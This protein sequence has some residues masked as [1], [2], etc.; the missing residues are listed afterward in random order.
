MEFSELLQKHRSIRRYKPDS[1]DPELIERV[2][3]DA[4]AGAST[5]GNLNCV[6]MVLTRDP[7]RKRRLYE[8]HFEQPM[9][10]EAPLVMTFCADWFR[11]REWLRLRGARD[12]FNNL[13]GY[14]VAAFDAIILAQNVCLGF[15]ANGL[16]ICYMGT[17][18]SS[19][20]EI[21]R[22]LELPDTCVPVTT[23]VVGYP[24]EEPSQRD[25]LP[26]G[27]FLHDEVY[28]PLTC[29]EIETVYE[30][31][32]VRGWQRY[33]SIPELKALIEERGIQSLAQFYTSEVKY[34]PETFRE[35]SERLRVL[36][37]DKHFLP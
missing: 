13:L 3:A 11:T 2:C 17:T 15:E 4:L 36:L 24:A 21:A 12:N 31:R 9:V 14:H 19:M 32:E 26:V 25:R 8:L 37:E 16:G 23:I 34:D 33:M 27:T 6:T 28:R 30:Q 20:T 10:L 5:S 7:D 1:I 35:D 29:D 22:F 18:L